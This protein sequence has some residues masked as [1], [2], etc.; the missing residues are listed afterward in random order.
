MVDL[1]K[2]LAPS[3]PR[4]TGHPGGLG[5]LAASLVDSDEV[6]LG[7]T[8]PDG[9]F[10]GLCKVIVGNLGLPLVWVGLVEPGSRRLRVESA[11]GTEVGYLHEAGFAKDGLIP[12]QIVGRSLRTGQAQTISDLAAEPA[13]SSVGR[14]LVSAGLEAP[15]RC[16]LEAATRSSEPC[17]ACR[18]NPAISTTRLWLFWAVWRLPLPR[19]WRSSS[20]SA[21]AARWSKT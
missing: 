14:W 4:R 16:Q 2:P 12:S 17:N 20:T 3:N 19:C 15:R 9:V 1:S 6:I 13:D 8:S 18:R 7:A 5:P 11:E 10:S 21:A